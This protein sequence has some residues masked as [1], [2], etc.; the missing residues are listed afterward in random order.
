MRCGRRVLLDFSWSRWGVKKPT[1]ESKDEEFTVFG[2]S[3]RD[4]LYGQSAV[5]VR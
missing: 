2:V 1:T 5:P 3:A 4:S